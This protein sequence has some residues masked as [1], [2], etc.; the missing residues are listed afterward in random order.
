MQPGGVSPAWA[1]ASWYHLASGAGSWAR[2]LWEGQSRARD[3]DD[4][5]QLQ[6]LKRPGMQGPTP[7]CTPQVT[8]RAPLALFYCRIPHSAL[9]GPAHLGS[10]E[11]QSSL[12]LIHH[13]AL[14]EDWAQPD[15]AP[16]PGVFPTNLQCDQQEPCLRCPEAWLKS[17]AHLRGR[18][19]RTLHCCTIG[20]TPSQLSRALPLTHK[21]PQSPVRDVS[22]LPPP[23]F[24][25]PLSCALHP[26]LPFPASP[27][28]V[29]QSSAA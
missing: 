19:P 27:I 11:L 25:V 23:S 20:L 4:N 12:R 21:G 13:P 5:H 18:H 9:P 29:S 26:S 2:R 10:R 14:W 7:C 16:G 28:P 8:C 1:L 22:S 6:R 24:P 17:R 3:H 15:G